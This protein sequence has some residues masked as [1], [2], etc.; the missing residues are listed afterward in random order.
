MLHKTANGREAAISGN[1]G[2][3]T[4]RFDV[5]QKG[6]HTVGL[7]IFDNQTGHGFVFVIGQ[8]QVEELQ[9]VT[10]GAHGMRARSAGA[11]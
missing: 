6:E 2:V 8:K 4:L 9:R 11:L 1:C 5:I 10:V 3:L 7:D